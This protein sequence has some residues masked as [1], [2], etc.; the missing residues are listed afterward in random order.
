MCHVALRFNIAGIAAAAATS[1]L[2]RRTGE[3]GARCSQ[4]KQCCSEC[5]VY[6]D[7]EHEGN[8]PRTAGSVPPHPPARPRRTRLLPLSGCSP[9]PPPLIMLPRSQLRL[10]RQQA[11]GARGPSTSRPRHQQQHGRQAGRPRRR[12]RFGAAVVGGARSGPRRL[13]RNTG[14]AGRAA[15]A[16]GA[17]EALPP[18]RLPVF[19]GQRPGAGR[20]HWHLLVPAGAQCRAASACVGGALVRGR[21]LLGQGRAGEVGG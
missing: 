12:R 20:L 5:N 19:Q 16:V 4:F 8:H 17:L 15:G 21:G 6:N 3:P 2:S 7:L 9:P 14:G 18:R 1:M 11:Q 10:S 13:L